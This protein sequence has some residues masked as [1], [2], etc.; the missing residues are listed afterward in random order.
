MWSALGVVLV[1]LA[2]GGGAYWY[3]Q[4]RL[5]QINHVHVPSLAEHSAPAAQAGGPSGSPGAG[6]GGSGGNGGGGGGGGGGNTRLED[7][8]IL[9]VGSD[10]RAGL[11]DASAFGGSANVT[12]A[13]SDVIKVVHISNDGNRVHILSIPRDTLVPIAGTNGRAKINA[14]FN[15]GADQLV[16]TITQDFGIP[17]NHYLLVNFDGFRGVIDAIGGLNLDF[18]MQLRDKFS[19]LDINHT[20]CQHIDGSTALALARS[21]HLEYY[22]NGQWNYAADGG[23][24]GRI[25]RQNLMIHSVLNKLRGVNTSNPITDNRLLSAVTG[26]LTVDDTMSNG[27]L[28]ALVN[29]LR[30]IPAGNIVSRTL[31]ITPK[32]HY[33]GYGDVL[34]PQ[35]SADQQAVTWLLGHPP[36]R[37]AAPSSG[38]VQTP[39]TATASSP[40]SGASGTVSGG[41]SATAS[42]TAAAPGS[43]GSGSAAS[44]SAVSGSGSASAG[45]FGSASAG[46]TSGVPPFDPRACSSS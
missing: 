19:G 3:L 41:A 34:L 17:I 39:V 11:S 25:Q 30:G 35:D 23:D 10:T 24:L 9:V 40:A 7:L 33:R 18:P 43:T 42:S 26:N 4:W 38:L 37:S 12:G 6:G 2:T 16:R 14:A 27:D 8:T 22:A 28:Y 31:P 29:H 1:L 46:S 45:S 13:R 20:G 32:S 15:G 44:G 5:G 21:R 36:S